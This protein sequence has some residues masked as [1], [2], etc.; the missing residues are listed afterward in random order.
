MTAS[1]H[2]HTHIHI[3]KKKSCHPIIRFNRLIINILHF[4]R[5]N[6]FFLSLFFFF[7]A[8]SSKTVNVDLDAVSLSVSIP[9][10]ETKSFPRRN[11]LTVCFHVFSPFL[12]FFF[13]NVACVGS[14]RLVDTW[15]RLERE[16]RLTNCKINR[17]GFHPVRI[18]SII[19]FFSP[20][21]K[22]ERATSP[23]RLMISSRND[24][25]LMP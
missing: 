21:I 4:L 17:V 16:T 14:D 3:H 12:F 2:T 24:L 25:N 22:L 15:S 8:L 6:L 1:E 18:S 11:C 19:S 10:D 5:F 7:P 13:P 9:T 20:P 23:R